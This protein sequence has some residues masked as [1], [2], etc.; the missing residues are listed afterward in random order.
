MVSR[1]LLRLFSAFGCREDVNVV[2]MVT[3]EP[4]CGLARLPG[5]GCRHISADRLCA[6]AAAWIRLIRP[7]FLTP[8][9]LR[10]QAPQSTL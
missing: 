5:H 2:D 6:R 3:K 1:Q 4:W 10:P 9:G 8:G 7:D